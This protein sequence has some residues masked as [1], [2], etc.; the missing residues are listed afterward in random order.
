MQAAPSAAQ[1]AHRPG[2]GEQITHLVAGAAAKPDLPIPF[3]GGGNTVARLQDDGLTMQ[4]EDRF[5][6]T[7]IQIVDAQLPAIAVVHLT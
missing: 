1:G 4:A 5:P 6:L 2:N 3:A 7:L